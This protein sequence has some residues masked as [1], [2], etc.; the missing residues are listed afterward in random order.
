MTGWARS[1]VLDL[2][3]FR[4]LH[5]PY[6]RRIGHLAIEQDVFVKVQLLGDRRRRHGIIVI[7]SET[8]ANECLL[9]YWRRYISVVRSPFWAS[10]LAGLDRF[11][12]LQV[13]VSRYSVAINETAPYV[14]VLRAWGSR[15]ALLALTKAHQR[16]GRARLADL[17]VP[18]DAEFICVHC[19][20]GG[21]SAGD[22]W[23]H[24][25]RSCKVENYLLA[26]SELVKRGFWCIRM[27]DAS[28]SRIEPVEKFIDYAHRDARS[29]FMDVFLSA[30]CAFFLGSASGL[31]WV[32]NVFGRSCGIANQTPL[33]SALAYGREDVAIHKLLWSESEER[34]LTFREALDSDIGNFRFSTLY[35]EHRIRPLENTPEDVRDLALEMLER[36]EGRAVYEPEDEELQE[37]FKSLM[38]PGHY[39]YGG[40][41]RVGRD[42]LRKYAYLL[43]DKTG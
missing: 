28:M 16:E 18:H 21:Y 27:G 2:V 8:V 14:S 41:N 43:G 31:S 6:R 34:Y 30:G 11:L 3:P 22:E 29:D 10:I 7:S 20:E 1:V 25:F 42:F 37:R 36:S 35:K 19:R 26:V 39:G 33:S 32:A 4:L 9:E 15:P 5:S 12:G 17:G 38:R 23:A 40:V 13:D 24:S